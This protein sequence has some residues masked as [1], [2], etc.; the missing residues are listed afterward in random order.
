MSNWTTRIACV[1]LAFAPA[2]YADKTTATQ[3]AP[4]K[5][6]E[7]VA[8]NPGEIKWTAAP[9]DL[10][11]GIQMAVLHGDPTKTG[12][13]TVRFKMPDGYTIPGH[14][15]SRDEQLTIISGT[16]D[17]HMGDSLNA[18]GHVLQTGGFHFLPAKMHHA[19]QAKGETVV[20]VYGSGPF[21][22]HYINPADNPNPKS[23]RR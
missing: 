5:Q 3:S 22:I 2:A 16:L 23:A 17:L 9:P 15:H 11:R 18:P 20:Q 8:L 10:P 19:A 7:P 14:W 4:S 1:L 21:D 13:F 12:N 6:N